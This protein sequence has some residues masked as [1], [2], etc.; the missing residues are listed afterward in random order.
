[1]KAI[2]RMQVALGLTHEQLLSTLKTNTLDELD[3]ASE[4][5]KRAAILI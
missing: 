1:M 3:A 2:R 5:G 4:K